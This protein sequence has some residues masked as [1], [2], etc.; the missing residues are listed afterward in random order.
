MF[1]KFPFISANSTQSLVF[2][3]LGTSASTLYIDVDIKRQILRAFS[4]FRDYL[5]IVKVDKED[6]EF[7]RLGG[8][9]RSVRVV[10]WVPQ[11][12]LLGEIFVEILVYVLV[13]KD[14]GKVI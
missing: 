13:F 10:D 14:F 12:A 7:K 9:F 8:Q 11:H 3:S 4:H 5:F 1:Q 6:E 2:F